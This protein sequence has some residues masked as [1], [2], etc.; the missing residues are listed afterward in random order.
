MHLSS[1]FDGRPVAATLRK[2]LNARTLRASALWSNP[3]KLGYNAGTSSAGAGAAAAAGFGPL[4]Q[5]GDGAGSI[6]MPAHFC[7]VFG[8][9]PSFGRVP[10]SPLGVDD[11]SAHV[12]PITRTVADSALM[13]QVIAGPHF[14]DHTTLEAGPANYLARLHDGVNGKRAYSD[15]AGHRF[16][17][18]AGQSFRFHSG[19]CSDLKPAIFRTDPGSR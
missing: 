14:L 10:Y 9:K 11:F 18:E 2:G 19:R 5:G 1:T 17:F 6:R 13:L 4:H 12:G 7:G 3:W 15:E 16:R 8:L